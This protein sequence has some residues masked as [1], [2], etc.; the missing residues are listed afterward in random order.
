[1]IILVSPTKQMN[2]RPKS[3]VS[4]RAFSRPRFSSEAAVLSGLL[5]QLSS[6]DLQKLMKISPSIALEAAENISRFGSGEAASGPALYSYSGTV[7]KALKSE[8]LSPESLDYAGEHLR[9]LSGLYGLLKPMDLISPYR[10]E[11]K[12]ALDV[13]GG[14]HLA[15]FWRSRITSAL[16]SEPVLISPDSVVVNLA[17]N[18]YSRVI[19]RAVLGRRVINLY[20]K[21][22]AGNSLKTVGMYAKTARGLMLR[23]ILVERSREPEMLK[24]GE[25]GGYCYNQSFSST[26]D[27]VFTREA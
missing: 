11:M 20:F 23:R 8:S 15:S 4:G 5:K 21:E 24:E 27:W 3:G 26:D 1:M 22:Q 6:S 2:F 17:S 7:F 25:T 14:G 9:I 13:P 18:E 16:I 12:T 19:D 10:L